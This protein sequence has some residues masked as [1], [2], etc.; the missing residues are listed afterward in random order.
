MPTQQSYS[1]VN[2]FPNHVVNSDSLTNEIR[3]S[4]VPIALDHIDTAEDTVTVYFKGELT[5]DELE[6]LNMVVANH[7]GVAPQ[8]NRVDAQGNPVVTISTY[9]YTEQNTKFKS[10]R[11]QTTKGS[12][13][14]FDEA[15]TKQLYIQGG[16]VIITDATDG[17]MIE[18]SIVDKDD[19][20][21]LFANYG[22]TIGTDVLELRKFVET[23]Y[24]LPNYVNHQQFTTSAAQKLAQGL[25]FRITYHSVA[26]DSDPTAWVRPTYLYYEA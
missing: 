25:Y 11:Y 26:T 23:V 13:T 12:I 10:Y 18:F 15:V 9:S 14:I 2:N 5:I 16:N 3:K 24:P 4:T 8:V 6:A 20:L 22:M 7:Q 1:I 19:T 17:D 21:G